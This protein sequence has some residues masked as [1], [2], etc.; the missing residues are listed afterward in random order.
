[1]PIAFPASPVTDET[2]SYNG[3]EWIWNG[4]AWQYN[5]NAGQVSAG[6]RRVQNAIATIHESAN[7]D[8]PACAWLHKVYV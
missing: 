6:W 1:M 3:R 7:S 2:Y 4:Y 8:L 5:I